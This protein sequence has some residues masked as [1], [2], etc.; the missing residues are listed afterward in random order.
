[1][2]LLPKEKWSRILVTS[3]YL[4]LSGIGIYLFFGKL[5]SL[6][7][8]FLTAFL[9]GWVLYAPARKLERRTGINRK[10]LSFILVLTVI[11][12]VGFVLFLFANQLI[13]EAQKL[14][15]GLSA[16]SGNILASAVTFLDSLGDRLPFI[17]EHLDREVI[18]GTVTEVIK[19]LITSLSS[20]LAAS[21]TL[22]VRRIPDISLFFVVFVIASFY[23][24]I[25]YPR[26]T[27]SL[28][29]MLPC[30]LREKTSTVTKKVKG[31]LAGYVKAYA[32]ILLIT[33]AQLFVGFLMIGVNYATTLAIIISLLDMLPVVGTG[34]VIIPW[35][36]ISMVMGNMSL[37][38]KLLVLFAVITVIREI[39]EPKIIG[40]SIGMHPLLTLIAMYAGYRLFGLWGILL[41]P[42]IVNLTKISLTNYTPKNRI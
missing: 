5:L 18:N 1:M 36:I 15:E 2:S 3:A 41:L 30:R 29:R 25:D 4:I 8:P 40:S 32:V 23:F 16:N 11:S 12:F 27:E 19:N 24:A 13:S 6:L 21:L 38:I 10:V 39:T 33:F 7:A 37:G 31:I 42:P 14:F 26:I 9:L 22:L 28:K 20:Y 35:A 34:T 17:Y